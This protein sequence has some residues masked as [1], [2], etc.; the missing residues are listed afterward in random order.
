VTY[1]SITLISLGASN[2][3]PSGLKLSGQL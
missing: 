2:I 3:P 1:A